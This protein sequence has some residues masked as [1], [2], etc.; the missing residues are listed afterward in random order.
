MTLLIVDVKEALCYHSEH[1]K[2]YQFW[3]HVVSVLNVC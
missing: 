2:H 1:F 3:I